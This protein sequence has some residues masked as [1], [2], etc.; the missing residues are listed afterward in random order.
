MSRPKACAHKK[1]PVK[2]ICSRAFQ[3][4]NQSTSN[5]PG[6]STPE[7]L[8]RTSH[9][10]KVA[11]ARPAA[12]ETLSASESSHSSAM[13]SPPCVLTSSAICQRPLPARSF[14][15]T[16]GPTVANWIAFSRPIQLAAP[17]LTHTRSCN[18]SQSRSF[19]STN[20]SPFWPNKSPPEDRTLECQC[21]KSQYDCSSGLSAIGSFLRN[22]RLKPIP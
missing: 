20:F 3:S 2:L 4:T 1:Y 16:V 14:A 9:L 22:L 19:A 15:T 6:W 18:P 17:V 10:P 13:P 7:L 11:S 12:A 5:R 21:P 8:N